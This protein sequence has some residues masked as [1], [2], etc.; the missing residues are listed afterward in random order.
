M[1]LPEVLSRAEA[2]LRTIAKALALADCHADAIRFLGY[3][4]LVVHDVPEKLASAE[5]NLRTAKFQKNN[6]EPQLSKP[7]APFPLTE[8]KTG[9]AERAIPL[10]RKLHAV[11]R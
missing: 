10:K 9:F 5:A 3:A 11:P 8:R 4:G 1:N 2:D 7:P 6:V